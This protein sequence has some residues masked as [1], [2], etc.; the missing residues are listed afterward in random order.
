MFG[1]VVE[2][3]HGGRGREGGVVPLLNAAELRHD[4]TNHEDF[5][6]GTVV[7]MRVMNKKNKNYA[8]PSYSIGGMREP[9][10]WRVTLQDYYTSVHYYIS[11]CWNLCSAQL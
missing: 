4:L 9:L 8:A 5:C 2:R 3:N 7:R 6:G 1:E 11:R 10:C